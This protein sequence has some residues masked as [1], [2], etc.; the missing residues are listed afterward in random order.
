VREDAERITEI[1]IKNDGGAQVTLKHVIGALEL[2]GNALE[3]VMGALELV[4]NA[5]ELV[6]GALE[7]VYS[8]VPCRL[9]TCAKARDVLADSSADGKAESKSRG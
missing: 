1:L 5:L 4:G 9:L 3:L 6:M 2:V 7:L 8:H